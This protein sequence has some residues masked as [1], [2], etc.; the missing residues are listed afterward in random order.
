MERGVKLSTIAVTNLKHESA[1]GNNI[2]LASDGTAAFA[3]IIAANKGIKFP[4]TQVASADPNTLDDY[5]EGTWTPAPA[6][7]TATDA[8]GIYTKIGRQVTVCVY[9]SGLSDI[10]AGNNLEITLPF[11]VISSGIDSFTGP[12]MMRY[13]SATSS[14]ENGVT[15][16]A[17]IGW[18]YFR[19]YQLVDN[20]TYLPIRHDSF[21]SSLIGL[22]MTMTYFTS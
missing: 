17:S 20:S 6:T 18:N 16:Y 5:E 3:E 13:F 10:S 21:S 9:M 15:A 11:T 22:R 7:G 19:I 12:V 2:T 8:T 4:S 14:E 1:S